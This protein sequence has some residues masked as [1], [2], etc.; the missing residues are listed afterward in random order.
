MCARLVALRWN[1]EPSRLTLHVNEEIWAL[2][3]QA[4]LMECRKGCRPDLKAQED[5]LEAA[6]FSLGSVVLPTKFPE[7][8]LGRGQSCV[9]HVWRWG[10]HHPRRNALFLFAGS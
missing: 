8:A 10:T 1:P 7:V 9:L 4:N 2:I 6:V 3:T 5:F